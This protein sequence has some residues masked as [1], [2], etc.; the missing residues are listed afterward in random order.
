M[1][2]IVDLQ[3][4]CRSSLYTLIH[5]CLNLLSSEG[6]DKGP[7]SE[8]SIASDLSRG[9]ETDSTVSEEESEWDEDERHI[10][11]NTVEILDSLRRVEAELI[12]KGTKSESSFTSPVKRAL[13][14]Q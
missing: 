12:R 6:G 3:M 9:F 5:A 1:S 4:P 7:E 2:E 11:S 13:V 8:S 14:E 10:R